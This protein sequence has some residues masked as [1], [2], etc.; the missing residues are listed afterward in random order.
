ML[1]C[2]K[3]HHPLLPRWL[4][5]ERLTP[6][7][8]QP[9]L[10]SLQW[11]LKATLLH[12]FLTSYEQHWWR[13]KSCICL[14]EDLRNWFRQNRKVRRNGSPICSDRGWAHS[15]STSLAVCDRHLLPH[16]NP[17]RYAL[18]LSS[19]TAGFWH[20][21]WKEFPQSISSRLTYST[22]SPRLSS[23]WRIHR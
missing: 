19:S 18:I 7:T 21:R 15:I 14:P 20:L 9:L 23:H 17:H 1:F 3:A 22:I 4:S 13:S 10:P 11:C 6:W 8:I 2:G 12:S 5:G 16:S